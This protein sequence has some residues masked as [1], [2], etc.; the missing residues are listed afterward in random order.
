MG[1]EKPSMDPKHA[2]FIRAARLARSFGRVWDAAFALFAFVLLVTYFVTFELKYLILAVVV[3]FA[4]FLSWQHH[5]HI[6]S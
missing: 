4:A 5:K 3:A 1:T 6:D 2:P